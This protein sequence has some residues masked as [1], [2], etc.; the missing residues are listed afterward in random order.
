MKKQYTVV[1]S[2]IAVFHDKSYQQTDPN[3]IK[4]LLDDENRI[5]KKEINLFHKNIDICLT[6]LF[7]EYI[8]VSYEW[9]EKE[10]VTCRK[11]NDEIE[12]IYRVIMPHFR[13]CTK[14]GNI[15]NITDFFN[16][17]MDEYYVECI[18]GT[19]RGF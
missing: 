11:N 4:I 1:V 6:E 17:A 7:N 15:L 18:T 19:P 14:K 13:D 16:L 3:Y 9:P 8:K 10:L 12:I 2:L 5:L